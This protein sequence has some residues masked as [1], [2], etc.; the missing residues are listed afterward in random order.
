[1]IDSKIDKMP[2]E[3]LSL[4][5]RKEKNNSPGQWDTLSATPIQKTLTVREYLCPEFI[6]IAA[7]FEEKESRHG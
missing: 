6:D 1:M 3:V 4:I 2:Y 7:K 5:Q